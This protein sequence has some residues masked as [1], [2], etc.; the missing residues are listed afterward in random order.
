MR[1]GKINN[2]KVNLVYENETYTRV[3]ITYHEHLRQQIACPLKWNLNN[4]IFLFFNREFRWWCM[5]EYR[6]VFTFVRVKVKA[7][8]PSYSCF[9]PR[10][11]RSRKMKET[12]ITKFIRRGGNSE[13]LLE[14]TNFLVIYI[15]SNRRENIIRHHNTHRHERIK[16]YVNFY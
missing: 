9:H 13:N 4:D 10:S 7:M 11:C 8:L 2:F 16:R 3:I 15:D 1:F 14:A 5:T 6:K 12:W